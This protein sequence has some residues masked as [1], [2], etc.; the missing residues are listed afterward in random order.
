MKQ[1]VNYFLLFLLALSKSFAQSTTASPTDTW[2]DYYFINKMY[3]AAISAFEKHQGELTLE[4]QRN[5]ALAYLYRNKKVEAEKQYAPV[6]NSNQARVAD[7]Y[8]YSNL[9]VGQNRLAEEY[10][11]KAYKLPWLTPSL[12][13]ND[14]LLFKKRF[15]GTTPYT[16][17]SVGGNT[18]N[19][20]FG[21]IFLSEEDKPEVFFLSDQEKTKGQSKALKRLK[22]DYPIYNFFQGDF[23]PK[24][25][26][27][28][29]IEGV[30]SSVNSFFQEGPGV[31]TKQPIYFTFLVV[32]SVT[33]KKRRC[34]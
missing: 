13:E 12:V 8:R 27:I 9:L 7:Y 24:A 31:T 1:S 29:R 34:N 2:G 11:T 10:R 5:F 6:A 28:S 20:E 19:N 18:P 4:Q 16:I 15:F 23:D 32:P 17:T 3:P 25:M 30:P 21:L 14:S 33:I 26:E 22:T